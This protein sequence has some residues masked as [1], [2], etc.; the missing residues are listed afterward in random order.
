MIQKEVSKKSLKGK[1]CKGT[2][3]QQQDSDTI[4]QVICLCLS[5]SYV[6]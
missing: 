4:Q 1:K 5:P 3:I 2:R 6:F